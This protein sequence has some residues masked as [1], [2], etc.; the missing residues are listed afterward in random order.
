MR[1]LIVALALVGAL[2]G[3]AQPY[4]QADDPYRVC[5]IT[6]PGW[7]DCYDR[8]QAQV[9]EQNQERA[10]APSVGAVLGVIGGLAAGAAYGAEYIGP[11]APANR[12]PVVTTS[13]HEFGGQMICNSF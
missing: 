4:E 9:H 13:C 5:D 3:C 2:A 8:V 6:K 12:A 11:N 1:K 7:Q 10:A